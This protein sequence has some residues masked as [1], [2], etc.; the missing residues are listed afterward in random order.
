MARIA[1]VVIAIAVGSFLLVENP[2]WAA[3]E[4]TRT[5]GA[6]GVPGRT[7]TRTDW[8]SRV[9]LAVT[10]TLLVLVIDGLTI[11]AIVRNRRQRTPAS[12]S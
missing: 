4:V 6:D 11:A 1:V 8:V 2:A 9:P 10:M 7:V 12:N 5:V 3:Q